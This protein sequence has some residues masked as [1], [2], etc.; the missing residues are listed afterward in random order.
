MCAPPPS[1]SATV[2]GLYQRHAT[3]ASPVARPQG[4]H[5]RKDCSPVIGAGQGRCSSCCAGLRWA[6]SPLQHHNGLERHHPARLHLSLSRQ[7]VPMLH[8][9]ARPSRPR[10]SA[11]QRAVSD[12]PPSC[13]SPAC[14]ARSGSCLAH[15]RLQ[16]SPPAP[17]CPLETDPAS[18]AGSPAACAGAGRRGSHRNGGR[19][20][21]AMPALHMRR[22][23]A[24]LVTH[25][26]TPPPGPGALAGGLPC[27]RRRCRWRH[28][29]SRWAGGWPAAARR[30]QRGGGAAAVVAVLGLRRV[31]WLVSLAPLLPWTGLIMHVRQQVVSG[32]G[33]GAAASAQH[34]RSRR[35]Q[36]PRLFRMCHPRA[37]LLCPCST[38]SA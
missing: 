35:G 3:L 37:S 11:L 15:P 4:F 7:P 17:T 24:W 25:P 1:P 16:R 29:T 6:A 5:S 10:W 19:E 21:G 8:D 12:P 27:R 34:Q 30:Q 33:T 2:P 14:L 20:P 36:P 13:R 22:G 18:E 31:L 28:C 38:P 9:L 26:P 23:A 32:G